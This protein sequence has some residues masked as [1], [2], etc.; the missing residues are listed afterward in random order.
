MLGEKK[1]A[2]L[3]RRIAKMARDPKDVANQKGGG[4]EERAAVSIELDELNGALVEQTRANEEQRVYISVLEEALK[5]KLGE[6]GFASDSGG[7]ELLTGMSKLTRDLDAARKELADAA[8]R[9]SDAEKD[10]E[11]LRIA[12]ES[13]DIAQAQRTVEMQQ[14]ISDLEAVRKERDVLKGQLQGNRS[15]TDALLQYVEEH[16]AVIDASKSA[17]SAAQ[18]LSI[19]E[20]QRDAAQKSAEEA[21]ALCTKLDNQLKALKDDVDSKGFVAKAKEQQLIELAESNEQLTFSMNEAKAEASSLSEKVSALE[22]LCSD[23]ESEAADARS[24]LAE[25]ARIVDKLRESVKEKER[26]VHELQDA[27]HRAE[28]AEEAYQQERDA[29]GASKCEI[30][31]LKETQKFMES[32]MSKVGTELAALKVARQETERLEAQ[33]PALMDAASDT[34]VASALGAVASH[35]AISNYFPRTSQILRASVQSMGA[36][37]EAARAKSE[38]ARLC[39][40]R[41][42]VER[43]LMHNEIRDLKSK[44]AALHAQHDDLSRNLDAAANELHVANDLCESMRR[45]NENMRAGRARLLEEISATRSCCVR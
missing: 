25:N 22:R 44:C 11:A 4:D 27:A 31:D 18:Q 24:S 41:A 19:I 7:I 37:R 29:H 34:E 9:A 5:A 2:R 21:S 33:L 17:L 26:R 6:L 3:Q 30:K 32:E 15:E 40:E 39:S 12:R 13:G 1:I 14:L 45:D 38:E 8:Q 23:L 10:A 43:N 42:D 28:R 36:L 35:P 20:A 16:R